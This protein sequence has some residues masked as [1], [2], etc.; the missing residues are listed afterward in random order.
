MALRPFCLPPLLYTPSSRSK[1]PNPSY[2]STGIFGE[3][4]LRN[5]VKAGLLRGLASF[6]AVLLFVLFAASPAS[7]QQAANAV[8]PPSADSVD[9]KAFAVLFRRVNDYLR[10]AKA[11]PSP[12]KPEAHLSRVIPE[13]F[14][15]TDDDTDSLQRVAHDW[16]HD[17]KILRSEFLK[18][19]AQFHSSFPNGALRPGMDPTPPPA[20][21]DLRRQMDEVTLQYR[22]KLRNT[23]LEP[24]F[25]KLRSDVQ[26]TFASKLQGDAS[27]NASPVT[28]GEVK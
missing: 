27:A 4:S 25:Q 10:L 17:S 28:A 2:I 11:A 6:L 9:A 7:A 13:Q 19:V 23:M 24:N 21:A 22:D 3:A 12:D 5:K 15:L 18:V 1:R 16:E 14:Q 20:L 8:T 26:K